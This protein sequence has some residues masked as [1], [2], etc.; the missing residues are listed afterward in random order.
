VN[1]AVSPTARQGDTPV[2]D[3]L[4]LR[5]WLRLLACETQV[6]KTLRARLASEFATTLPRFDVLAA[7]DRAPA[8]LQLTALSRRLRVSNGN[9]T[10]VVARLTAEGLIERR[11][12]PTDGRV[13]QV[14][15]TAKGR[16]AFL[17]M[18]TAH[19]TWI[20]EMFAGLDTGEQTRAL[21]LLG[22]LRSSLPDHGARP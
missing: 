13:V 7:L 11:I 18:A 12:L 4:A 17:A 5:L 16:A 6:E 21:A 8:G 1:P 20:E 22:T 15:L 9:V 14:S 2:P 19:E 3:K 10:V